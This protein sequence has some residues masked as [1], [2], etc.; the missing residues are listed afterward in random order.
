MKRDGSKVRETAPYVAALSAI[1]VPRV[2]VSVLLFYVDDPQ[3]F[4]SSRRRRVGR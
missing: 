1:N 3:L 4:P 2:R